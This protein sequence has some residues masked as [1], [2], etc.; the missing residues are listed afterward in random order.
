MHLHFDNLTATLIAGAIFL[1]FVAVVQQSQGGLFDSTSS[2][3][4]REQQL[5]FIDILVRDI[6]GMTGAVDIEEDPDEKTFTF[7]SRV[8]EDTTTQIIT[9]KRESVGEYEGIDFYRIERYTEDRWGGSTSTRDGGSAGTITSWT[10]EGR[11]RD[12]QKPAEGKTD[13]VEQVFVRFEMNSRYDVGADE[14]RTWK[15]TFR[16]NQ[17]REDKSL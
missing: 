10:I 5:A 14:G 8:G 12:N 9:Y 13:E 6:R 16:P 15:A 11:N 3:T 4:L 2:S 7:Y 17:L 1:I